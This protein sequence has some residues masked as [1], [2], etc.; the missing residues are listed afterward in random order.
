M[1][2]T[3]VLACSVLLVA[4]GASSPGPSSAEALAVLPAPPTV[5]PHE[6]D[7]S[8]VFLRVYDDSMTVVLEVTAADLDD[9]LG[10]GWDVASGIEREEVALRIDAIRA[11][12]ES[13][14]ELSA[15]GA[16]LDLRFRAW[17][18][19]FI[20]IGEYVA[21]EYTVEVADAVP[22]VI[23]VYYPV[24]FEIDRT[25][26]N[27]LVVAHNWKTA[28]FN[29]EA[30]PALVFAP[31][32]A[33]QSLDLTSASWLRGFV[34]LIRLGVLHIW[35]GYDHIL[36]LLALILPSVLMRQRGQWRPAEGFREAFLN[37]L[38][39]VTAFTLAHSVTLALAGFDVIELPSRLVESIIAASIAIAAGANLM[40]GLRVREWAVALGFGLFHGLGFAT[41]MGDI[42]VGRDHLVPSV[43]GFNLGVEIGQIAIVVTVFPILYA[44]RGW[45]WYEPL[46][47]IGSYG[48][49][50]IATVWLGERVF[51]V[52]VPLVATVLLV[53]RWIAGLVGLGA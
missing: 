1:S 21:L 16:S 40:P 9:A 46:M 53:P 27:L 41:V 26:R 31:G 32:S 2:R 50:A 48:L 3:A 39:I 35:I 14:F 43:L 6:L 20:E 12:V 19:L 29:N 45:R 4:V 11:Y 5:T 30:V 15:G 52:D 23:D 8:Y 36:F 22:D 18:L 10:F 47:R 13:R 33:R 42:G 44:M 7:Q 17:D 38:W 49:I 51:D 37:I 34:G 25:H 28:T 24:F